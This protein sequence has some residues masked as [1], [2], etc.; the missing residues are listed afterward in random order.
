MAGGGGGARPSALSVNLTPMIDCTMLLVIFF[1]L[2]TQMA[3]PNYIAMKLPKPLESIAQETEQNRA[4]VNVVPHTEMEIRLGARADEALE[5]R[6]GTHHFGIG[7]LNKLVSKLK[8]LR[9]LSKE[10]KDFR[11]EIRADRRLDYTQVEPIFAALQAAG[12][13]KVHVSAERDLKR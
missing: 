7:D 8:E 6:V 9:S 13:Q 11:V 10:P 1:L 3:S 2:T 4:V 5:Y 12:I